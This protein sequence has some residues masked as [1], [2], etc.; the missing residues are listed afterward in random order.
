[1]VNEVKVRSY[2]LAGNHT[3]FQTFVREIGKLEPS[4]TH[5]VSNE[6]VL[7]GQRGNTLYLFGTWYARPDVD[8]IMLMARTREMSI[9]EVEDN[10]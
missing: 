5:Y 1:M 4:M 8:Q 7:R 10:R 6:H 9:V 3:Q 2:V